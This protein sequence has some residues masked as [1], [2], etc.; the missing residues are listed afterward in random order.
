[1]DLAS[2]R[3]TSCTFHARAR[4]HAH[5]IARMNRAPASLLFFD[6][7]GIHP[8][9]PLPPRDWSSMRRRELEGEAERRLGEAGDDSLGPSLEGP[10]HT[11]IKKEG[12]TVA[13]KSVLHM[14]MPLLSTPPRF[15]FMSK[16]PLSL[17]MPKA[18]LPS[19]S[20]SSPNRRAIRSSCSIY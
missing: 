2:Y 16:R 15:L 10:L 11:V 18:P 1:M 13:T 20:S 9:F 14:S 8:R 19:L 4:T 17:E 3:S 12:K 7:S 5:L 6:L